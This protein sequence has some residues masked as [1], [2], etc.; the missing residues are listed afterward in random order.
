[1]ITV[2][3][4]GVVWPGAGLADSAAVAVG[5]GRIVALGQAAGALLA[6]ADEV[7][8]L[9]G[10]LLMP[11]FGDG[12]CHPDLA[13]FERLGPDI[14]RCR[15]VQQIVD[16]VGAFAADHPELDWILGGSYDSTL[17]PDGRFDARWL[18]AA[19]PDRPV[20]LRAWDYHT[21]W[22]NTA[23][24]QRA[25]VDDAVADTDRGHFVR[26]PDGSLMGTMH[27]WDAVNAILD[28]A[29]A[30]TDDQRL[31]ALRLATATLAAAGVTWVQDAWVER[32][33]V[34][35]YLAAAEQGALSTRVNLAF[36]ADPDRWQAQVAECIA[37][38]ERVRALGAGRLSAD[39]VKFFVDGVIETGTAVLLEPYADDPCTRGLPV[40][41]G[42]T[43]DEAVAA[44]DRAGFA[45]HLHVIGDGAA[46]MALDAIERT[47]AGNGGRDRRPVLAHVQVLDP[48]DLH[49]FAEL[50]VIASFQPLWA[51]TDDV[52]RKLTMPRLGER[53][54]AQQYPIASILRAGGSVAFGSDWPV[55]DH[56]PLA[57]L[58]VAV[59]RLTPDG[60]P[61]GGWLPGERV[62]TVTALTAYTA[63][64][65]YQAFAEQDRGRLTVGSQADLVWLDRDPRELDPAGIPAIG[66]LGTWLEGAA[67]YRA[68][69]GVE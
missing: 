44:F 6:A 43:L 68:A 17:T 14:R 65:A 26:R 13:G 8:D 53:R 29:P 62:D 9:A 58:P 15:S 11:A 35:S 39:T 32:A 27:E 20:A 12:H 28:A 50:G 1:V 10:G 2:F 49:R 64:V 45:V 66:V 38:R 22:C 24:M 34:P 54:S 33:A 60:D 51:Q 48:A 3:H 37:D 30:W 18:D 41:P 16:V 52:M 61:A 42:A 57:G 5:N 67:T 63:G 25:G 36:R 55:S 46:R 59:S 40:W 21:V 69:A 23:A 56:R 31:H 47:I 4:N 19:V 7:V